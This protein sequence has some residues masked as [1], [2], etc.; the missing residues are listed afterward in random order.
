M[1][2]FE[3]FRLYVDLIEVKQNRADLAGGLECGLTCGR[4][5]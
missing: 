1:Q 5:E 4:G 2:K 3:S